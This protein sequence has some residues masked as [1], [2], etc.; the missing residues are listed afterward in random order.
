MAVSVAVL[1]RSGLLLKHAGEQPTLR[2][3]PHLERAIPPAETI[4]N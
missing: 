4:F 1:T 3:S 2:R